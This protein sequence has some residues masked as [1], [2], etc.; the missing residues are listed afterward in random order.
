MRSTIHLFATALSALAVVMSMVYVLPH[1]L[2]LGLV[3]V[4][5]NVLSTASNVSEFIK[6]LK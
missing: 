3:L 4:I 2:W 6:S 5:L 1:N